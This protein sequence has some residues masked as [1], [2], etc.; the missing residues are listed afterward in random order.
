MRDGAK[1]AHMMLVESTG[2]DGVVS[3]CDDLDAFGR[4]M[5]GI[6]DRTSLFRLD[7]LDFGETLRSALAVVRRHH[8]L[9]QGNYSTMFIGLMVVEGIGRQLA[10]Q[11]N[12]IEEAWPY[13]LSPYAP[14]ARVFFKDE[15]DRMRIWRRREQQLCNR[16]SLADRLARAAKDTH[17][18]A[19]S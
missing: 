18:R 12:I 4:D 16:E 8:V 6:L 15:W 17:R 13:L 11:I 19:S 5:Q 14:A 3:Q 1:V 10:P 2:S 7:V 9:I